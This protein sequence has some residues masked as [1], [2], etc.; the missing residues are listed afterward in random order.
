LTG[1]AAEEYFKKNNNTHE[2]NLNTGLGLMLG[3][4]VAE[5]IGAFVM[6]SGQRNI[7]NAVNLYTG[8]G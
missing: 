5:L 2:N 6:R 8:T 7:F 4:L 1:K 3:G